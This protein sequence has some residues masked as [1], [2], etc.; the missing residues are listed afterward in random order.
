MTSAPRMTA[1]A[2]SAAKIG[3]QAPFKPIPMP[4]RIRVMKSCSHVRVM[5]PPIGVSK[6]KIAEMKIVPRRPM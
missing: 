6:Q 3:T 4:I 5:P 1:G 2:F